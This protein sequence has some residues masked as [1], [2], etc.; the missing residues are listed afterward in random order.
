MLLPALAIFLMIMGNYLQA[1]KPNYLIGIRTPWTLQDENNWQ[2]THR[3]G[4][5]LY[6]IGGLFLFLLSL[7][8]NNDTLNA[9]FLGLLLLIVIIPAFFS[10]Y[11]FT[12][13]K[14]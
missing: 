8:V 5:K 6:L 9:I 1:I 14:K 2:L 3:F 7:A 11:L 12:C 13:K 10:F 4:G